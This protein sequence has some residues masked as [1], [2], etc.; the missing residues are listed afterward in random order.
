[1]FITVHEPGAC[2]PKINNGHVYEFQVA[3]AVKIHTVQVV[4]LTIGIAILIKNL[5]PE[6][7]SIKAD[8]L[9]ESGISSKAFLYINPEN[10]EATKGII[11]ETK[12]HVP[13]CQP[14]LTATKY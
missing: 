14:N 2:F 7:P 4:V 1:M 11:N 12:R 8:S 10:T 6:V 13:I 9:T 5:N 3:S